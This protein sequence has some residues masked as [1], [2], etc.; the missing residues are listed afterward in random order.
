MRHFGAIA[1][2]G[3]SH[4]Q[5]ACAIGNELRRLGHRFTFFGTADQVRWASQFDI[6]VQQLGSVDPGVDYRAAIF[7]DPNS[8]L[9]GVLR[10]M[11]RMTALVCAEAPNALRRH[12]IDF[13][14]ADQEEPGAATAADIAR[15]PYV[16]FCSSLPLNED[17]SVPPSFVGW[18]A[19]PDRWTKTKNF[20]VYRVRNLAVRG[21][22][23]IA[24]Q[25]RKRARLKPYRIPDDSFSRLGHFSQLVKDFDFPRTALP[26]NFNYVGPFQ[27]GSLKSVPFPYERLDGRPLVYAAFGT[28]QGAR[29]DILRHV[30]QACRNLP[31]QLVLSLGGLEV[32]DVHRQF[33]GD[34]VIV[35]YAPQ[36][37]LLERSVMVIA[38]AGLN[39]TMEALSAGVP[40]IAI[41]TN[42]GDQAGV[43]ARI[44][45]FGVGRVLSP[46][47]LNSETLHA[48]ISELLDNPSYRNSAGRMK[49]AVERTKGAAQA[50]QIIHSLA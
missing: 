21:V 38:H 10:Y 19:R 18:N 7:K 48:A 27:R 24:N 28:S 47:K 23:R 13:L 12:G 35:S 31:I 15:I 37:A 44:R 41:P 42:A 46:K 45:H 8:F 26:P 3:L 30:A 5:S 9:S 29:T 4:V 16:T 33:P 11:K 43:A 1:N 6:P 22:N 50:A 2:T 34:P 14:L 40:M 39:T 20:L 49:A 32:T 36:C 17:L 25:Y